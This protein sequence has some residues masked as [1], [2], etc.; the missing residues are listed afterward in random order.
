MQ[1]QRHTPLTLQE[2]ISP[3][4]LTTTIS[5]LGNFVYRQNDVDIS[6]LDLKPGDSGTVVLHNTGGTSISGFSLTIPAT[7]AT[8]IT[9]NTCTAST[10]LASGANC[11]FSY[12]ILPSATTATYS[13]NATGTNANNSPSTLITRINQEGRFVFRNE[14]GQDVTS[15][16]IIAPAT[17]VITVHN[18][19]GASIG[20]FNLTEP[21]QQQGLTFSNNTCTSRDTLTPGESCSISYAVTAS[22]VS[23]VTVQL[24]AK[25]ALGVGPVAT[26][27]MNLLEE[28]KLLCWGNDSRGELGRGESIGSD[29]IPAAVLTTS[30]SNVVMTSGAYDGNCALLKSGKVQCWGGNDYG[31][32][33]RDKT[34][35][36]LSDSSTPGYVVSQGGSTEPLSD[37]TAIS[38]S[39]YHSCA[40]L[41]NG[42]V[43]C[44]GRNNLGELGDGTQ[45]TRIA[46]VTVLASGAG[47]Y[48]SH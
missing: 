33:G 24:T 30:D 48:L 40:L 1:Q 32:L 39:H 21:Q 4:T 31:E 9:S 16:D 38:S 47:N 17:G 45:T 43:K 26:L 35:E 46:P 8:Y 12:R 22:I 34:G 42:T 7:L 15:M 14:S 11:S 37:V 3:S 19:G 27:N 41:Q 25:G 36:Q 28:G 44:W 10:L 2:R 13:I 18:A 6:N 23:P 20:N 29:Y 5:K